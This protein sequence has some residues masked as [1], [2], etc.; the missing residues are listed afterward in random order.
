MNHQ[1]ELMGPDTKH[2]ILP[3][4]HTGDPTAIAQVLQRRPVLLVETSIDVHRTLISP[5]I[6]AKTAYGS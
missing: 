1:D 6:V 5:S 3:Q 4:P 2:I